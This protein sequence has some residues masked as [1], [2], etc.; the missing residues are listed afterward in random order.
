VRLRTVPQPLRQAS[1]EVAGAWRSSHFKSSVQVWCLMRAGT[2][3][4]PH[5]VNEDNQPGVQLTALDFAADA[6]TVSP[7]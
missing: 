7:R 3:A 6:T 2:I 1:S 4:R 5:L